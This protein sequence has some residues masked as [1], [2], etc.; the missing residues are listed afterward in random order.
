MRGARLNTGVHLL[1]QRLP[2]ALIGNFQIPGGFYF[3]LLSCFPSAADFSLVFILVPLK[4]GNYGVAQWP[5]Q[6]AIHHDKIPGE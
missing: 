2:L 5:I 4:S 1:E 6:P 3:G